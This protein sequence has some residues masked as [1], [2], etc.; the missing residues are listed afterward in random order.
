[1]TVKKTT[2]KRKT[3]S[4]KPKTGGALTQA[5][6][7]RRRQRGGGFIADFLPFPV[8]KIAG[9]VGLGKRQR[10]AGVGDRTL[11]YVRSVLQAVAPMVKEDLKL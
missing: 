2:T 6:R 4:G 7:G 10:G 11:D 3:G 9:M 5:G 1:M 8:N